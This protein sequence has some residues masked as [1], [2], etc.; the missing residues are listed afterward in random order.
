MKDELGL[1]YTSSHAESAVLFNQALT[2]YLASDATTMSQLEDVLFADPEM[3]MAMMFR[4][5]LLKLAADPRFKVRI[6]QCLDTLVQR[7]DLNER[8]I[9]HREALTLW[10]DNQLEEAAH[11]FDNIICQYPRD[12]LAIRVA[13]YLHFY[14]QG[15]NAMIGSLAEVV[16]SWQP[17]EPFYGYLK[18]M[19][20]FAL[21]EL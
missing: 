10:R 15:G 2:R 6:D 17:D 16:R 18:G 14:G 4:A 8:E 19:E 1:E 5:Y 3:P 12:M 21:E 13:H 9:L 20:C 7:T 11:A